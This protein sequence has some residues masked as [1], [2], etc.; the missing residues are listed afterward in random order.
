VTKDCAILLDV[1][2]T[3][4]DSNYF[5]VLAWHRAFRRELV[6]NLFER[7]AAT[8]YA[9]SGQPQDVDVCGKSSAPTSRSTPW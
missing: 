3:L 1:D 7:G 6:R 8:V 2:G 4:V 5:H 9:T